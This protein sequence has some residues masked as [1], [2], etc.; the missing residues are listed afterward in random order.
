MLMLINQIFLVSLIKE[1]IVISSVS[2]SNKLDH[3]F[4][5]TFS[6]CAK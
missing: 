1:S 3:M 2:S 4:N 6:Q 5:V